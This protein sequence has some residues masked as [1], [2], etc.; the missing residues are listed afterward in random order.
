LLLVR[1]IEAAGILGFGDNGLSNPFVEICLVDL[2]GR[3]IE[4]EGEEV[5]KTLRGTQRPVWN[6]T[7]IFGKQCDL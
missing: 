7:V 4:C 5:T 1:V 6:Y 3:P 2:A